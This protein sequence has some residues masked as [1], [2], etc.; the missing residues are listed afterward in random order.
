[1]IETNEKILR[2]ILALENNQNWRIKY[3]CR[4]G[5]IDCQDSF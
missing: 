1:M 5:V 2:A 4:E 3:F